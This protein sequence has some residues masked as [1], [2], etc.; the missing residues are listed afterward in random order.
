MFGPCRVYFTATEY[1]AAIDQ[2]LRVLDAAEV[3]IAGLFAAVQNGLGGQI[4]WGH[5]LHIGWALTSGRLV[6]KTLAGIKSTA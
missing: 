3:P 6:G 1:G 2:S 4:L 5:S